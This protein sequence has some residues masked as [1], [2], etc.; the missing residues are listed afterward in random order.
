ME[1]EVRVYFV[2]Y[3][4]NNFLIVRGIGYNYLD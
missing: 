1:N 4:E 2:I 3:I